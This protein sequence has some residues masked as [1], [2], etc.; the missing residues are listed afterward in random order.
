MYKTKEI[1][2]FFPQENRHIQKWFNNLGVDVTEK[3][4]DFYLNLETVDVG[5]K[6]RQ[7]KT[8]IKHRIGQR[9]NDKLNPNAWGSFETWIKWSFDT[10]DDKLYSEISNDNFPMWIPISKERYAI[11]VIESEGNLQIHPLSKSFD[12]GCQIEYAKIHLNDKQCYTFGM[13]WFGDTCLKIEPIFV[14]EILGDTKFT[15]NQ[16]YGY[17]QFLANV[18]E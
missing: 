15:I 12:Y 8:E 4:E 16:S 2:W 13:E 10:F 7:G 3:R 17:P 5:V 1:R 11:Q 9:A 6:L 14:D 18:R